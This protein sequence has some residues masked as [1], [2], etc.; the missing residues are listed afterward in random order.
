MNDR[1]GPETHIV[2]VIIARKQQYSVIFS[3]LAPEITGA[4]HSVFV[5][6]K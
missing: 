3:A 5:Y 1:L 6:L 2:I 4:A